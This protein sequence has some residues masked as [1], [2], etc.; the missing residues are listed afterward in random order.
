MEKTD[1]RSYYESLPRKRMAA[2]VLLFNEKKELL[3]VKPNY[4]NDWL[5]PGGIVEEN[6]SPKTA[7]IRE[8]KEEIGL[9]INADKL[10]FAGVDYKS[11]KDIGGE[12]VHFIFS[13]G[14]LPPEIFERIALQKEELDEY[15]FAPIEEALILLN[16]H[17]G[18]RVAKALNGIKNT[19]PVYLENGELV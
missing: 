11:R 6:E 16:V 15:K 13:G 9:N 17:L 14:A 10:E 3:I 2:A 18:K 5:L 19:T 1:G 4:R 7:A 12:M 8:L